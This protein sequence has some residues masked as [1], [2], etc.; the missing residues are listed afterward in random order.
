MSIEFVATKTFDE[1][2]NEYIAIHQTFN[3]DYVP[4]ESDDILP[5]LQTFA[6]RELLLRTEMNIGW[7]KS[8]W[9]SATGEDLD[10]CAL[11]FFG[12]KR[13][14][15]AK[16][17]ASFTFEL[18]AP[19][20]VDYRIAAGLLLSSPDGLT[21]E[22]VDDIIIP[23]G[24]T[25]SGSGRVDLD[26]YVSSTTVKTEQIITPLPY[27]LSAKQIGDFIGGKDTESDDGLRE[28]I[29]LSF[30]QFSTAGAIGAYK[31]YAKSADARIDDVA[32]YSTSDAVVHVTLHSLSGVDQVMIDRVYAAINPDEVRPLTDH[33]LVAA[34]IAV[35]YTISG[36]VTID[37][38]YD[39][40]TV[41]AKVS[42]N[43]DVMTKS[44]KIGESV[45]ISKIT[46][47]IM[48]VD[49]VTDMTLVSP[50]SNIV[51][52]DKSKVAICTLVEVVNA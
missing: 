29:E 9:M 43:L 14:L 28:R 44:V 27:T 10:W 32:V 42:E 35:N 34:A 26:A 24:S 19:M 39:T 20:T 15:G 40:A 47:A 45:S 18:A 49:G 4:N 51:V 23:A 13:L 17:Y 46:G 16:P 30:E 52:P 48:K 31:Y 25:I 12:L 11:F 36:T 21:A 38:L 6:Y 8:Y 33:V 41:L 22:L 3:P 2:V 1:I 50:I 37:P 7:K 5:T